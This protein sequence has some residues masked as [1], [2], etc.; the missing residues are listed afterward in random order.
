MSLTN[1]LR[2]RYHIIH[3][4]EFGNL[5]KYTECIAQIIIKPLNPVFDKIKKSLSDFDESPNINNAFASSKW[6]FEMNLYQQ[7]VTF[8]QEFI[9]TFFCARHAIP[10]NG[11]DKRNSINKAFKCI[12]LP[13]N[14]WEIAPD[15]LAKVKEIMADGYLQNRELINL[16]KALSDLRNDFNHSGMRPNP[17]SPAK[18]KKNIQSYINT[19]E[20]IF[21]NP[22][23]FSPVNEKEKCFINLSN[24]PSTMW[25][26]EQKKAAICFG[27]ICDIPF[28]DIDPQADEEQIIALADTYLQ[29]IKAIAC[30]KKTTL[31]IMGEMTFTFYIVQ[32]CLSSGIVCVASTTE[33]MVNENNNGNKE[34]QF[35]F[36]QFR[37]YKL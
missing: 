7:S 37:E 36:V 30:N 21:F 20:R 23:I 33:R 35:N 8:L 14:E 10:V 5:K 12:D 27:N 19:T 28:T 18:I 26:N 34:V 24:H 13:E 3:S 6:C 1:A 4:E 25:S 22:P 29:D 9:V 15:D 2:Q 32:Q 16:F 31:H 11:G 17:S